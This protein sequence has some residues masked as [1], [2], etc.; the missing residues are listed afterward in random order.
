MREVGRDLSSLRAE[1]TPP[2]KRNVP[3][4]YRPPPT[5]NSLVPGSRE[6]GSK[7]MNLK[8]AVTLVVP[9][10]IQTLTGCCQHTAGHQTEQVGGDIP[11]EKTGRRREPPSP[12]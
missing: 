9:R 3:P 10:H 11:E 2:S 5:H 6:D 8:N 7:G 4:P 1:V 12:V